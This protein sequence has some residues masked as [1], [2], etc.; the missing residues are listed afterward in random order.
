MPERIFSTGVG[1][2]RWQ[3]IY[4]CRSSTK[5]TKDHWFKLF[6]KR[7]VAIV[8]AILILLLVFIVTVFWFIMGLVT[9][10]LLW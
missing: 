10:G 1:S 2:L 8:K 3:V 6:K 7:C 5:K 4:E 9:V